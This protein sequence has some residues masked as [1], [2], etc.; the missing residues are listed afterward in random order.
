VIPGNDRLAGCAVICPAIDDELVSGE[1]QLLD[2]RFS[3]EHTSGFEQGPL[4]SL[5]C[6]E[7]ARCRLGFCLLHREDELQFSARR[8]RA[9]EG[10][11]GKQVRLVI[12]PARGFFPVPDIPEPVFSRLERRATGEQSNGRRFLSPTANHDPLVDN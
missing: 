5:F 8:K 4:S 1:G 3:I 2:C 6:G 12:E 9:L 11:R 10:A 7:G